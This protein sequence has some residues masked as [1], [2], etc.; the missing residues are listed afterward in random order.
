MDEKVKQ[1]LIEIVDPDP[2]LQAIGYEL[3]AMTCELSRRW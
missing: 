1:A 2:L 3:S